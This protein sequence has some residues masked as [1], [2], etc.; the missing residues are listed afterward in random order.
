MNENTVIDGLVNVE[1]M[2]NVISREPEHVREELAGLVADE[3]IP[4]SF[5]E[6]VKQSIGV[7]NGHK[8]FEGTNVVSMVG[9]HR[10]D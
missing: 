2:A 4:G 9:R 7:L 6:L 5:G 3:Q 8:W 10:S 1:R